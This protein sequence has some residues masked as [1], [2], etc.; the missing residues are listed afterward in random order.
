LTVDSSAARER[1]LY[2]GS[3]GTLGAYLARQG[4]RLSGRPFA[5]P[6]IVFPRLAVEI[7]TGP[8]QTVVAD[9]TSAILYNAGDRARVRYLQD[10]DRCDYLVLD[11]AW[12]AELGGLHDSRAGAR[13]P[14]RPFGRLE[15]PLDAIAHLRLR[16]MVGRLLAGTADPLSVEEALIDVAG[17]VLASAAGLERPPGRPLTTAAQ[18]RLVADVKEAL[19]AGEGA[20]TIEQLASLVGASPFHLSRVFKRHTGRTIARYRTELRLRAAL[21]EIGS[22]DLATLAIRH[23]FASHSHF[24]ATFRAVFGLPPSKARAELA[25]DP[26]PFSGR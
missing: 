3:I 1:H 14:A 16:T 6:L 9:A 18:R 23:G 24:S 5:R 8:G 10:A 17:R 15:V 22:D 19:A 12:L 2:R 21:A 11:P 13:P 26:D 4:D 20:M 25:P 7:E